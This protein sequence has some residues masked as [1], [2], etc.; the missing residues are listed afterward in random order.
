[1]DPPI[2]L[3]PR[4]VSP[5]NSDSEESDDD[6][7]TDTCLH[8]NSFPCN[9]K[10]H[11]QLW[12]ENASDQALEK[13]WSERLAGT[14]SSPM[15]KKVDFKRQ[16]ER[17]YKRFICDNVGNNNASPD[18]LRSRCFCVRRKIEQRVPKVCFSGCHERPCVVYKKGTHLFNDLV[19]LQL[20]KRW[21]N[22]DMQNIARKRFSAQHPQ[23]CK[24]RKLP[25][26]VES[27]INMFFPTKKHC[28][29][30]SVM[31][32]YVIRIKTISN[33]NLSI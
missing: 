16:I 18:R 26:C 11:V 15:A 21:S 25:G 10:A 23:I 4:I 14:A 24:R 17:Q 6:T 20:Q 1:M 27:T 28:M 30:S 33:I 32:V 5:N 22:E 9:A 3:M 13:K 29:I 2:V 8:C 12:L 31:H 19:R 7:R